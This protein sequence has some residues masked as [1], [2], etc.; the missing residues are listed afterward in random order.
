MILKRTIFCTLLTFIFL[1]GVAQDLDYLDTKLEET[2]KRQAT[3]VR[4]FVEIE[5]NVY[6]CTV[7]HVNGSLKCEG[8]YVLMDGKFMEHGEFVFYYSNK[9]VESKGR[10]Q[11]GI[12]VGSWERY[13]SGGNRRPD[14]YYDPESA[15]MIRNVMN[16]E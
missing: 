11:Y 15:N 14:R 13:T 2:K 4:E 8:V 7:K 10:Y 5:N 16:Q 1:G 9:Q 3:Y 12:K 6:Q